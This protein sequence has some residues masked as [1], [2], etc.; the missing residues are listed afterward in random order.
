MLL[1]PTIHHALAP[2]HTS[3]SCSPPYIMLLLPT[4]HHALAPHHTSCSCSPPYIMLLLP[5]IHHALAPHHT[6]CSCSPPYIMLLLPTIPSTVSIF[7]Q[8]TTTMHEKKQKIKNTT[9][10]HVPLPYLQSAPSSCQHHAQAV[11]SAILIHERKRRSKKL[12]SSSLC[13]SN[14]T[15]THTLRTR[16]EIT[17]IINLI[18]A[19]QQDITTFT[20][21]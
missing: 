21:S 15:C 5:T 1:L 17:N 16:N 6:S 13:I 12:A 20:I 4:I 19:K 18:R 14:D 10:I 9:I 7:L 8:P 11:G 3:C 2:H